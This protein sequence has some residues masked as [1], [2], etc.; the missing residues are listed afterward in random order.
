MSY[1]VDDSSIKA[2]VFEYDHNVRLR[3]GEQL[4]KWGDYHFQVFT[5]TLGSSYFKAIT[6][7][8]AQPSLQNPTSRRSFNSVGPRFQCAAA[9]P[10]GG[11]RSSVCKKFNFSNCDRNITQCEF[12]HVCWECSQKHKASDCTKPKDSAEAS[13]SKTTGQ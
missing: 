13:G 1:L 2:K 5:E 8:T 7:R 11:S 9:S 12:A 3:V 10:G 6:S 4:A